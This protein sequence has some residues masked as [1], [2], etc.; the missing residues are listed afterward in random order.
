MGLEFRKSHIQKLIED[1]RAKLAETVIEEDESYGPLEEREFS[2]ADRE[3]KSPGDFVFPDRKAWP[4]KP[5]AFAWAAVRRMGEDWGKKS[6]YGKIAKAI[7]SEY[8]KDS[9]VAKAADKV[10]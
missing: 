5:E 10:K 3:K 9:A 7:A 8:G 4:Y 1:H 2:D 6:E